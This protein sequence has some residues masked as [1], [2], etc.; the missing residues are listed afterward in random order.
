MRILGRHISSRGVA[1]LTVDKINVFYGGLQALRNVSFRIEKGEIIAIVGSNGAGKTT[2]LRTISGLLRPESG[3]IKFLDNRL[4]KLPTHRIVELGVVQIPEGRRL[5]PYMTVMENL[6]MGAF[7]PKARKKRR[8][9]IKW[10]FDLFPVLEERRN[11]L[12][13]TLSGGEQQML[14]I[15]R[16]LMS[17]PKLLMLDE[18]SLGLAPRLVITLFKMIKKINEEGITI[19]LVEQNVR[20][21]LELT[22]RGYV[23]ETGRIILEGGGT[24]LIE[25]EYVKKAYLGM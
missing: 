17:R 16:G 19:L 25:S 7:A 4:D 20:H 2:I 12:A 13:G 14:A 10:I 3:S 1:M 15:G 6:E 22:D 18:P 11:Q 8:E 9:T 24:Q 5:F 21:A 23:L